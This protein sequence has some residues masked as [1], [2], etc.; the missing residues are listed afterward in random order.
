MEK[1]GLT[2]AWADLEPMRLSQRGQMKRWQEFPCAVSPAY[3]SRSS[4]SARRYL[5]IMSFTVL[6]A[7]IIGSTCS[8]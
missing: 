6:P 2:A 1:G 5:R 4:N 8:V 3:V 7:G